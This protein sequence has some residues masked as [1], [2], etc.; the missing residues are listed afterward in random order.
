MSRVTNM[1]YFG[2]GILIGCMTVI[3][4]MTVF[5]YESSY[6]RY[7]HISA[8]FIAVNLEK[9]FIVIS[10][11]GGF[12]ILLYLLVDFFYKHFCKVNDVIVKEVLISFFVYFIILLPFL[13]TNSIGENW[14]ILSFAALVVFMHVFIKPFFYSNKKRYAEKLVDCNGDKNYKKDLI[15][16]IGNYFG[17][18]GVSV[19]LFII[20]IFFIAW[21]IGFYDASNKEEFS[22]AIL[23]NK[24]FIIVRS[25]N[26]HTIL[27]GI[28]QKNQKFGNSFMVVNTDELSKMKLENRNIGELKYDGAL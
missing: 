4:Y 6:L 8:E 25:Y 18:N 27:L 21:K 19:I 10:A 14:L 12:L 28:D 7:Y 15:E 23:G 11:L 2:E 1:K 26:D 20:Y 3:S 13:Y 17:K 24:E 16:T 5:L 22:V 9:F